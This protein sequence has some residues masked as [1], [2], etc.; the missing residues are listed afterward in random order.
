VVDGLD[1]QR[2]NPGADAG[3]LIQQLGTGGLAAKPSFAAPQTPTVTS[4]L[5]EM[6]CLPFWLATY[7]LLRRSE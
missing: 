2:A 5:A 7:T 6:I 1:D 3:Q 4:S